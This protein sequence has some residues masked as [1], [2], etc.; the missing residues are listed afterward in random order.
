MK[1]GS[2]FPSET[3]LGKV[4]FNLNL[5]MWETFV[6]ANKSETRFEFV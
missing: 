5:T 2:V 3:G 1:Y 6:L 4:I